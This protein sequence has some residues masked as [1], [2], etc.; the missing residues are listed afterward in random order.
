MLY[1]LSF[2]KINEHEDWKFSIFC[3]NIEWNLFRVNLICIMFY[4]AHLSWISSELHYYYYLFY[5]IL[6][7]FIYLF[8][9]FYLFIYLFIFFFILMSNLPCDN[10]TSFTVS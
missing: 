1:L 3:R 2:P 10:D 7:Y 6:F 4:A 8:I 9:Y 5:F